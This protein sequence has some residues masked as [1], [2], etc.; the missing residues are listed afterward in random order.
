MGQ[1]SNF[2]SMAMIVSAFLSHLWICSIILDLNFGGNKAITHTV[3]TGI[4][5]SLAIGGMKKTGNGKTGGSDKFCLT[6]F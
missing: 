4:K 2:M 1:V 6:L 3:L 5:P